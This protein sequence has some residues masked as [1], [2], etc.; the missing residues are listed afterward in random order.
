MKEGMRSTRSTTREGMR[1]IRSATREGM[2]STRSTTRE[3][4]RST[5]STTREGMRSTR[6]TTFD[7]H[8]KSMESWIGTKHFVFYS[9]YNV[10]TIFQNLQKRSLVCMEHNN[11]LAC[12]PL[13]S[14][15]RLSVLLPD[16][17]PIERVPLS[18]AGGCT[19]QL[20]VWALGTF[21]ST[22]LTEWSHVLL[23]WFSYI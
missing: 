16:N 4:M 23:D 17:P 11:L 22:Q 21:T 15:V 1:S 14:T 19:E 20:W 18:T 5:R 10:P 7:C 3:G 12:Y 13:W 9:G 8:W 6:S 2:R